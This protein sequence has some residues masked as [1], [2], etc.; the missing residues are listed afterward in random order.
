MPRRRL[1]WHI[2]SIHVVVTLAALAAVTAYTTHSV[3]SFHMASIGKD[4]E[5]RAQ[6]MADAVAAAAADANTPD[7]QALVTRLGETSSTR[8]TVIL[9][10]GKVVGDSEESPENMDN[11]ANRPEIMQA[12]AGDVGRAIRF[13]QTLQRDLMYLAIPLNDPEG[14]VAVLRTAL[15]L[16][17]IQ[18]A[19]WSNRSD[20]L[21][22]VAVIAVLG[23]V[24]SWF[25]ARQITT[26][27][28][29]LKQGADLFAQG[30]FNHTLRTSGSEEVAALARAM[31]Q[32]A[33]ELDQRIRTIT[34]QR[35]QQEAVLSSMIEGVIAVDPS[36]CVISMNQSAARMLGVDADEAQGTTIESMLRNTALQQFVARAIESHAPVEDEC[37]L[38]T[39]EEQVVQ[40]HGTVLRD[41]HG[42][43]LGA[44][45]V[46]N[47]VSRLRRL[48][49]VRQDFVANVS[50]E[51][52]TPITSIKGF[53]ETLLD[54]ALDNVEDARHFLE[55]VAKQAERLNAILEDL[56]ILSRIEED[57]SRVEIALEMGEVT[58]A[59]DGAVQLC[60]QKAED[61]GVLL[62][63][64]GDVPIEAPINP[65]LLEQAVANL[66][67]NAIKYSEQGAHVWVRARRTNGEVVIEVEDNGCGIPPEHLPRLFERF[68]RVDKAR[69]RKLGGTGLGLSIVKHIANAH[70]GR[71]E[72][73]SSPGKRTVF[74]ICLPGA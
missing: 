70:N 57:K 12:M 68:Y 27:L 41:T 43:G 7:M 38:H 47:D 25:V 31:N 1:I 46:L 19:L 48:E 62:V 8:V 50:H 11:H 6:L 72:V 9:P 40:V 32:M 67:D 17:R 53:I 49:Q 26:P 16:T 74:S 24:A 42:T 71:V 20:I 14:L 44:V 61:K 28:E 65:R 52:R 39:Q 55:I 64:E 5:A 30:D 63:V 45:I 22:G 56:M 69:S 58:A 21:L 37:V 15:P 29:Q 73:V 33:A 54:G 13:S 59:I 23:I 34:N 18:A 3:A 51:L 35:N 2:F 66:V 36:G 60:Q 10:S 4:L